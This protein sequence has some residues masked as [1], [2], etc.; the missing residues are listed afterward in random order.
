[1]TT[2]HAAPAARVLDAAALGA[3][4]YI[5]A[6]RGDLG[7]L[8][9]GARY[10]QLRSLV[11]CVEDAVHLRDVP[12]ALANLRALLAELALLRALHPD[13]PA[14]FVRPR[15][16]AMLGA[17][18][19][20][21]GAAALD[22]FVIPKATAD[23]LPSYISALP[24]AHQVIMPTLET[25]EAFD[26]AEMV[27]L[28]TLMQ[29]V[30]DRVLAVRI[31][32]NDLLQTLGT[33]RSTTRTAY[34]G[35]LGTVIANLVATFVPWGF[36]M[37]A[38][39]FESFVDPDRLREE[40]E[41]DLEHGL[42]TKSAIHPLQVGVIHDA[43]RVGEPDLATANDML[44]VDAPAIFTAGGMM[45]E[46]ST[47]RGWAAATRRRAEIFGVVRGECALSLVC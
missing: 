33:R 42:M 47:H 43:Y 44:A 4:L 34:D 15:N 13:G 8:A 5:P 6:T 22:G 39:V 26:T 37:S 38:P 30:P 14:L 17:I 10:P 1:V 24:F 36:A 32:G 19:A 16:A 12:A 31:G 35:P 45:C 25:R 2:L 46:P 27:R 41:R 18:V 21:P 9:S 40:V 3:T 11:F 20:M 23:I 29:A 28:R 7:A